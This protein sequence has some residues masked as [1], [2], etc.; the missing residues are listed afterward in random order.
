MKKEDLFEVLGDMDAA[1]V[2]CAKRPCGSSGSRLLVLTRPAAAV[3]AL[4]MLAGLSVTAYAFEMDRRYN[5]AVAYLHSIGV[6]AED[7]SDYSRAEIRRAA[8]WCRTVEA[9][10][11]AAVPQGAGPLWEKAAD[12]LETSAGPDA[13]RAVS[14]ES[15]RTLTPTMT[16]RE[17][18]DRLGE[19]VDVGSGIYVLVYEVDGAYTLTIPF[20]GDDAQLGVTG[21]AL[22]EA[23]RP[24]EDP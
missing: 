8:E 20:A 24:V 23:L 18:V 19:T 12:A 13:P 9:G 14:S 10:R 22:L 7:L 11:D 4:V 17:V 6:E 1:V 21:E 3:L 16:Y 5:A 15:I 2:K